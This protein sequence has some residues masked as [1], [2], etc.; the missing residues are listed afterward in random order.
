M[1]RGTLPIVARLQSLQAPSRL[2]PGGSRVIADFQ[3]PNPLEALLREVNE[4]ILARALMFESSGGA[5]LTLEI[6]GRRVLRLTSATGLS[7]ADRCLAAP[8]LEEEQKDDLIKLLQAVAAPK[9]ELRV[10]SSPPEREIDGVSVGFPVALLAD[11]CLIELNEVTGAHDP[12][13]MPV[14]E[15]EAEVFAEPEEAPEPEPIPPTPPVADVVQGPVGAAFLS[16]L[17]QDTGPTLMA[18]VI[19]GGVEDGRT[20]GPEEMVSHLQGFL[21]DEFEPLTRQLDLVSMVPAGPVCLVLGAT[22]VSGHSI[23][24]ARSGDG[25]LVGVIEGDGTQ[26]LLRAW[27]SAN[28]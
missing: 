26:T 22:L 13:P 1:N 20:E 7:G 18:W 16:R 8:A 9:H 15:P 27:N 28:A 10:S 24:C 6:S 5:S 23:L 3:D 2:A 25:I 17:A 21:E 11:L 12:E 14:P 4:T 19:S